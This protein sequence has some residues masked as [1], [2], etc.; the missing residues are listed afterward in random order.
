MMPAIR[1]APSTSPFLASPLSTRS[2]VLRVITT[3]PAATATR[4]VAAFAD[5]STMRASPRLPRWVS[6]AIASF[7]CGH[8]RGVT[9]EQRLGGASDIFLPHQAF[10]DQKCRDANLFQASEICE[11]KEAALADHDVVARDQRREALGRF[12]SC[13]EGL[14]VAVVDADQSRLEPQ[15]TVEFRLVVDLDQHVH[16]VTERRVFQRGRRRIVDAGHDDQNAIGAPGAR[17]RRLVG[18]EHEVL[19]QHGERGRSARGGEIF[20]LALKRRCIGQHGE[21]GSAAGLVSARECRR[22][23]IRADQAFRRACLLDL[24]DQRILASR[25]LAL[26][27]GKK[28]ARRWRSLRGSFNLRQ[29]ARALSRCD[30]LALVCFDFR[31]DVSHAALDTAINRSRRP[32]ASAESKDLVATATPSF[33]SFALP[34]TTMAAAA[35]KSA[36]SRNGPFLPLSTSINA[37]AFDSASPP[38][39]CSGFDGARPNSSGLISK[40]V[41]LPLS[42]AATAVGPEVVISSSPSE[43]CT[44]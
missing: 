6:F 44:T 35:F 27:R 38:R 23:E 7:G 34:A 12:E 15:G 13:L 3:R 11:G 10:A 24:G 32:S 2:S 9:R 41:T 1:A 42:S 17:L 19:A 28:A 21:A 37:A 14:Q 31:Q 5:T 8:P 33:R 25:V 36:T 18:L 26:D 43:P 40:V 16:A 20:G 4:S 29:R 39:N 30:L 22:I